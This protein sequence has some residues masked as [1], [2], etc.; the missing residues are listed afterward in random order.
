[1]SV[2]RTAKETNDK[3]TRVE[4]AFFSTP[5]EFMENGFLNVYE[6]IRFQ[7]IV[8]FGGA[9]TEAASSTLDKLD[10]ETRRE[11]LHLYF[12]PVDGLGYTLCRT[13]INSCDF[14]LGNYAYDETDGDIELKDFSIERDRRS[15]L[16]MIKDSMQV[17]GSSFQLFASP[18]SPP[19]W[20]KT[21]GRMNE[22]GQL[23]KEY[24]QVWA[25][26]FVKYLREYE[27]EGIKFW[28][29]TLQNEANAVTEWDSCTYTAEE[30]RDFLRD[31]L[32]PAIRK[33][34]FSDLNIMFWDHNKELVVDRASVM[35][36]DPEAAKYIWG[37]AVHW[38]SGEHFDSLAAFSRLFPEYKILHTEGCCGWSPKNEWWKDGET[39]AHGI[40]G[41]LSNGA[42]G[43]VDWNMVLNENGGPNHVGNFCNA[44]VMVDTEKK[45]FTLENSYYCMGH[46][47]KFIRPGAKR[48]LSTKYCS[49]LE[50]C[51]FLNTDNTVAVVVL[52]RSDERLEINLRSRG[53]IAGLISLPHSIMTLV[54]E[55]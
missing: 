54:Y 53:E 36:Q 34:G 47:S 30:E 10:E 14:S 48:V 6:D 3:L 27:K 46:F 26:Y 13:H 41:D 12:S 33:A 24:R 50:T 17:P 4:D 18:W 51:A 42:T 19:A 35:L 32:G 44:P 5:V 15:L 7:E 31:Y 9:F 8:G 52:N 22:G 1:M 23:K 39:Y 21:T 2:Y 40:I 25:D 38:Y 37:I 11:I 55:I 16:P 45:V 49:Q 29:I 43:W 28:G 20:M